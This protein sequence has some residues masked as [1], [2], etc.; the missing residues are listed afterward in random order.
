M[1]ATDPA[2]WEHP[3]RLLQNL[4]RFDTTSPPGNEAACVGYVDALLTAAGFET[5]ALAVDPGRPNL[6]TRLAGEGSAPPL[7]LYG[8]V[9]VVGTANQDWTVPPFE[10]RIAD[11]WV[12]GRGALDMKGGVAMMLAALLRARSEG[13]RPAG[14]ILL[15]VLSDEEMLGGCGAQYLVE[16]HAERFAGVRYAIGEFG[17]YTQ[18]I[19]RRVLY[20]IQVAEK[21][22]CRLKAGLRGQGGHPSLPI[23]GGTMARLGRT[24][25]TLGRPR[26]PVHVTAPARTMFT[27]MADALPFPTSLAL[28]GLLTP[29]LTDALLGL[30]GANGRFLDPLL[31]N[32]VNVYRVEGDMDQSTLELVGFLL[33]GY[34]SDDLIAELRPLVGDRLD[35]ELV[36]YDPGPSDPRPDMGLFD[37]LAGILHEADPSGT[38]VPILMPGVTDG[39]F[40]SRLGIQ[41]YGYTPAKLPAGFDYLATVHAADERIP[42]DAVRFGA[43]AMYRLLQVYGR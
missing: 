43:D 7:L 35:L 32:T 12:W 9:D 19:G 36:R 41:T 26:L 24:L 6:L 3:E 31:H 15:A 10:G 16:H 38:P 2:L 11:G 4:I 34:T 22:I 18:H 28:R 8:H 40:F 29:A 30:L 20:P 39:R 23:A 27:S 5:T 33:P 37:T 17:G 25:R 13:L 1:P 21:Q 14:D 42:V